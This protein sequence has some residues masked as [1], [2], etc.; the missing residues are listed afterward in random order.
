MGHK[1]I[2]KHHG[3]ATGPRLFTARPFERE[4]NTKQTCRRYRYPS[5][6][7]SVYLRATTG[8]AP[9]KQLS[10][11]GHLSGSLGPAAYYGPV[12][13]CPA[14]TP[15][16]SVR[17]LLPCCVCS[18]ESPHRNPAH[19]VAQGWP[20]TTTEPK[21]ASLPASGGDAPDATFYGSPSERRGGRASLT[22]FQKPEKKGGNRHQPLRLRDNRET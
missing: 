17:R 19:D 18:S 3:P 14:Y 9:V 22:A 10:R 21:P 2:V 16:V 4:K 6:L 15:L 8:T 20:S 13:P 11:P 5:S 7:V 1:H 12:G